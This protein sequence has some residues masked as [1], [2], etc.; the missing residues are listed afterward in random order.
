MIGRTLMTGACLALVAAT[1]QAENAKPRLLGCYKRVL[2]PA[3]YNVTKTKIKDA[4][5][6]YV[7]RNG[8]YELLEYP[9]VFEEHKTLIKGEYYVMQEIPCN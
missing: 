3:E 2:M 1:A 9:A 6:K 7:K 8:R 5:R 4:E